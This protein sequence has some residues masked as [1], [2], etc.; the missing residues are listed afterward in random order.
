MCVHVV[1]SIILIVIFYQMV[2][3]ESLCENLL[4]LA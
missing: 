3:K 2:D 4:Y 1:K